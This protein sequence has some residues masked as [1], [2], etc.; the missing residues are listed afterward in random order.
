MKLA[1]ALTSLIASASL[2]LTSCSGGGSHSSANATSNSNGTTSYV[3]PSQQSLAVSDV[4]QILAQAIAE[5]QARGTPAVIA[6]TDRVGNVLAVYTMTGAPSTVLVSP[7]PAGA[8]DPTKNHDLQG[9]M[10]SGAPAVPA[11]MAAIAKA[12]TGAYLSSSGNAFSTRTASMIVQQSFPPSPAGAGQPA[13]ALF[14]VQFSQLPCS[15]LSARFPGNGTIGPKRSPLGF[16]A[17]PGGFPLYK[18]G[19][20]VGGVG[21]VSDGNYDFEPNVLVVDSSDS[22]ENIAFAATNGY[23]APSTITA[24]QITINGQSL[25]YTDA[26]SGTLKSNPAS[27]PAFSS[28]G[29]AGSLTSVNGY[30]TAPTILAGQA[31]GTEAS[32][33]RAATSAEFGNSSAFVL[34]DGAGHDRYPIQGGTDG[35]EVGSPL[36]ATE[37]NALLTQAFNIMS[38]ARSQIRQPLNSLAEVSIS[39]V[40]THGVVLGIVRAPDAP[41]FGVDVSLQKA[42]TAA[43][44]SNPNAASDLLGNVDPSL[45]KTFV[46]SPSDTA[47]TTVDIDNFV[48]A[49]QTFLNDPTQLTGKTAF[50]TRA[51]GNLSRPYFPDG[52]LNTPNGP[53]SR[54]I[55]EFNIFST[56]LQ[57]ALALSNIIQHVGFVLGVTPDTPAQCTYIKPYAPPNTPP[58]GPNRLMNGIQIFAGGEPIY[59]GNQLVGAIGVSGDGTSQDDMIGFLGIYNAGQSTGTIGEAP[60]AIR[61]DQITVTVDGQSSGL[62]Y[63]SCPATPFVNSSQQDVCTGK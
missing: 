31:Y 61:A 52:E 24:D 60:A 13:G 23:A 5:A 35:A 25:Q 21:V 33:V 38:Q 63:V 4:Q 6:V 34:T 17:D 14:G 2:I 42:R 43:F 9:L 48:T 54:A 28:L 55:T 37:V 57:S 18:N 44:F 7:S 22:E 19:V 50:S 36:T 59:R 29:G 51:I 30:Y 3:V 40:D 10:L 1:R 32:G 45:L 39:V 47:N 16:S 62:L 56:G 58:T 15:D 53:L 46:N 11:T 27:A 49:F 8:T 20:V 26:S 12:I 41:L